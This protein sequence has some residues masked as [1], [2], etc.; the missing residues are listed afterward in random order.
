MI[1]PGAAR[2]KAFLWADQRSLWADQRSVFTKNSPR[3]SKF[4]G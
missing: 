3:T 2:R 4:R 1:A